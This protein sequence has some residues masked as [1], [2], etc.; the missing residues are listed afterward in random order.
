MGACRCKVRNE[1][2]K[3]IV[4]MKT[5]LK[6]MIAG[7]VMI[8]LVVLG[9]GKAARSEERRVGKE[10]RTPVGTSPLQ[11][12]APTTNVGY[13]LRLV[14]VGATNQPGTHATV[15]NTRN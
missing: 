8:G 12:T 2:T 15:T 3:E 5:Q 13:D 4:N 14:D 1:R 9:M 6:A 7:L 10:R 11:K